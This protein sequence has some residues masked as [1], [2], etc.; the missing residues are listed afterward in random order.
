[1]RVLIAEDEVV[2]R[3]ILEAFLLRLG[4]EVVSVSS[5]KEALGVLN[6][7]QAPNL[8][9]SEPLAELNKIVTPVTSE[10]QKTLKNLD[11]GLRRN[12]CAWKRARSERCKSS[13][14]RC[15]LPV[16][17]GNCVAARRGGEQPE[18]NLQSVGKRTRFGRTLRRAS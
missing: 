10:V 3:R 14:G 11:S 16:V 18:T 8:V 5:G 12:E 17:K 6:D 1:M 13:P 4:Y 15:P 7:T 2:S 9:I